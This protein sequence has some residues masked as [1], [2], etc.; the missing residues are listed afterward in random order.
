MIATDSSENFNIVPVAAQHGT[1]TMTPEPM[2]KVFDQLI[3]VKA[4]PIEMA[5]VK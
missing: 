5:L 3:G 2:E 4:K 1:R